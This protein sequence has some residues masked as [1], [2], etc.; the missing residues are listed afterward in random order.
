MAAPKGW[1][2][3]SISSLN[4][5]VAVSASMHSFSD[6]ILIHIRT[7]ISSFFHSLPHSSSHQHKTL[8]TL[9]FSFSSLTFLF[10]L[11]L[12]SHNLCVLSLLATIF[13]L[14]FSFVCAV[15]GILPLSLTISQLSKI[16]FQLFESLRLRHFTE[17][18][19]LSKRERAAE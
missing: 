3:L 6:V 17:I 9:C 7:V 12:P 19:H 18:C 10:F 15:P 16:I 14:S 1:Y 8:C 5:L 4:K 13:I 2:Q 11:I